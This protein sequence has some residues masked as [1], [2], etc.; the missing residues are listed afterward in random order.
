M[1]ADSRLLDLPG[2]G[3]GSSAGRRP[4]CHPPDRRTPGHHRGHLP[5]LRRCRCA[6]R[7]APGRARARARGPAPCSRGWT[8]RAGTT[9]APGAAA[10]AAA[11][12]GGRTTAG[13]EA[14]A[15]ASGGASLGVLGK[16]AGRVA[17]GKE[18]DAVGGPTGCLLVAVGGEAARA[19]CSIARSGLLGVRT[20]DD[21]AAVCVVLVLSRAAPGE[22][23]DMIWG[24][25]PSRRS[26]RRARLRRR[27]MGRLRK[28][29]G[30]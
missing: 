1:G 19:K 6:P 17:V 3:C 7:T 4:A 13:V 29:G 2:S 28:A 30:G 9:R 22:A 10:G 16:G 21:R 18:R 12:T 25:R 15:S 11:A 26:R 23:A 5:D 20:P 8:P 14:S 24:G 27:R